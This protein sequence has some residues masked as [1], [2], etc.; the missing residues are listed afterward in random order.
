MNAIKVS[1][2]VPIYK[3]PERFLRQC[4]ESLTGQTLRELEIILVDDG[5]PDQCGAICDEYASMDEKIHVIHKA[6]AGVS[7][8][9]NVGLD[10]CCGE[11]VM[12]V[13]ADDWLEVG[14]LER[15]NELIEKYDSDVIGFN[16]F[17]NSEKKEWKRFTFPPIITRTGKDIEWLKLD[18]L[19]PYYDSK[20][21]GVS[22]GGIRGV[23]GKAFR[24]SV[25]EKYGIRFEPDIKIAEDAMFCFDVFDK[26]ESVTLCDECLIHY[27]VYGNSVMQNYN[28]DIIRL[29][30]GVLNGYYKRI[31]DN[32]SQEKYRI[33]FLGAAAE[34]VFRSLKLFFLHADNALPL[35]QN[36]KRFRDSVGTEIYKKAL[37]GANERVLPHG[38]REMV[39]CVKKNWIVCTFLIAWVAIR[40]LNFIRIYG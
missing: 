5:S 14:A 23:W 28:P 8:A 1:V 13:D 39:Y 12:F 25:I 3:V 30:E 34:C 6:N 16:H 26:S 11:W 4:I 40:I 9:R 36:C 10:N 20:K 21:N 7:S 29:N 17:Y 35:S 38:K 2:I 19:F 37:W 15:V 33:A 32:F 31:M 22:T 27:R 24:R 18:T